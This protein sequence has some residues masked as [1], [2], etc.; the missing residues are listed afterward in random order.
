MVGLCPSLQRLKAQLPGEISL[1]GTDLAADLMAR[2]LIDEY[3]LYLQPVVLR[4]GKPVFAASPGAL[5]LVDSQQIGAFALP[6][7]YRP[8]CG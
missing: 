6:L 4:R 7:R 3:R 2:G 5:E 8:L 1:S